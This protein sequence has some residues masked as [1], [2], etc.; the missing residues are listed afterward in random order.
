[1]KNSVIALIIIVSFFEL[2]FQYLA[3]KAAVSSKKK[4]FI[5]L[6]LAMICILLYGFLYY[7]ILKSRI[8]LGIAHAVQHCFG[9]TLVFLMGYIFFGQKINKMQMLGVILLTAGICLITFYDSGHSHDHGHF[10]TH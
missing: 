7:Y 2:G 1:M 10:H 4:N 3:E 8:K 5:P 6:L 9:I